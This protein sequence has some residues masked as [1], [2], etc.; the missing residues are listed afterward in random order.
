[1]SAGLVFAL[2][3]VAPALFFILTLGACATPS[4]Y[5]SPP[6]SQAPRLEDTQ[7][8]MDDGYRLPLSVWPAEAGDQRI[9]LALHGLNDYRQA[10]AETGRYLAARGITLYA[11]DQR[12]FGETAGRGYWH[13]HQRLV[14][15]LRLMLRLLRQAHPRR[16][17][18]VLGE[19]M[20]GAV[21]LAALQQQAL[22]ADGIILIAPAVW[23]RAEMPWYQR[24]LLW[25]AAHTVPGKRLSGKGLALRPSDN[26]A[27]LKALGRDPR[28]IKATRVDVLYGVSNLMDAAATTPPTA[29]CD[30]LILYGEHDE[31]I[32]RQPACHFLARLPTDR[33]GRWQTVLYEQGFHMLTRDLQAQTV[34]DDIADWLLDRPF[35]TPDRVTLFCTP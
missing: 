33:S 24:T 28:V 23:P 5:P 9:V 31:I 12:G 1:M 29:S 17:L 26:T 30:T 22:D 35:A 8:V 7:A 34:L 16:P 19:S 4:V 6:V 32:P 13:G 2:R 27:M 11:Y 20:G 15:D 21:I 3:S 10:F 18:Y 25:F 14:A